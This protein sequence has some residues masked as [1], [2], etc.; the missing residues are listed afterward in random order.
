MLE[1]F[2]YLVF[3][4][5]DG[6]LMVPCRDAFLARVV[7]SRPRFP[8]RR[9]VSFNE[10]YVLNVNR[11]RICLSTL[12]VNIERVLVILSRFFNILEQTRLVLEI[13]FHFLYFSTELIRGGRR[14]FIIALVLFLLVA[15]SVAYVL[16]GAAH[17]MMAGRSG[18]HTRVIRHS[19]YVFVF[20]A[21]RMMP[22]S[23]TRMLLLFLLPLVNILVLAADPGVLYT[24]LACHSLAWDI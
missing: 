5:L 8:R 16:G 9:A 22:H 14:P 7:T 21:L 3:S 15:T 11:G 20:P 13:P 1:T 19:I 6:R 23:L 10:L 18:S 2:L 17:V 12:N 4:R 24:C